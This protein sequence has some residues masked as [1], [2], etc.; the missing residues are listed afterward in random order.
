[1]NPA[2]R[3]SVQQLHLAF[4][5]SNTGRRLISVYPFPL[6]ELEPQLTCAS[7]KAFSPSQSGF[8]PSQSGFVVAK[9]HAHSPT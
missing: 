4:P 2:D 3:G 9:V 6:W 5:E 1:M 8:L 7:Q